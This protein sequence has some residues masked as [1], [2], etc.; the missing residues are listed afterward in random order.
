[1]LIPAYN[2]VGKI[3]DV[4]RGVVRQG[5]DCLVVDDGS[6]DGTGDAARK[7]GARVVTNRRNVGLG[8]TIRRAY[9]EALVSDAEIIVQLDADGQ[10][11]PQEIPKVIDPIE[12][13]EADMVLGSRL[14][15]LHY[16]M[17]AIK[18]FGNR[19][20]SRVLKGLTGADVRDGQTGFRA[21]HREVLEE[22]APINE[23][24]YTQEMI[25]RVAKEKFRIISVPIHFYERYDEES[26]LFHSSLG[27]AI[28]GWWIIIRTWRDYHPFRFFFGPALLL[29]L[30]ALVGAGIVLEH[31]ITTGHLTGRLGMLITSG[32]LL[33]FSAQLILIGLLADLIRTHTKF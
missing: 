14:E 21:M 18:R 29:L 5:Y 3:A 7:A 10:Y 12:N 25:I 24:S 31:V 13:G 15:N 23:F 30:V 33:L 32:V 2:E 4:V 1:M 19:A 27:F 28:K 20:F 6:T 26:R 16:K 9:K 8:R 11:D 17:P 22:C